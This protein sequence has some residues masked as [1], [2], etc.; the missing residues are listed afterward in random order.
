M[1]LEN[2]P[3]ECLTQNSNTE[4]T[5]IQIEGTQLTEIVC[6]NNEKYGKLKCKN[7]FKYLVRFRKKF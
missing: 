6:A 7:D 1:G 3:I 4:R 5:L 2:Y